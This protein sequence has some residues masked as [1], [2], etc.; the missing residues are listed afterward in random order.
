MKITKKNL[1]CLIKEI[2]DPVSGK[3]K[4]YHTFGKGGSTRSSKP[5]A[6]E[7][8]VDR[9]KSIMQ[10][11]FIP[12]DGNLFGEGLYGYRIEEFQ[13][14]KSSDN[15]FGNYALEFEIKDISRWFIFGAETAKAIKGKNFTPRAQCEVLG[16]DLN[17][18]LFE[19]HTHERDEENSRWI[20]K[21]IDMTVGDVMD[22]LYEWEISE[23]LAEASDEANEFIYA[24]YELCTWYDIPGF[25][26][27]NSSIVCYDL[28]SVVLTGYSD[29]VGSGII[30]PLPNIEMK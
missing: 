18:H 8:V 11:G 23:Y 28:N 5:L 6:K 1:K 2:I 24:F 13:S 12:G 19:Y 10:N 9:V 16:I 22:K 15:D 29:D 30:K 20:P 17:K 27:Y 7:E 4:M 14:L 21:T 3:I 26:I 25:V